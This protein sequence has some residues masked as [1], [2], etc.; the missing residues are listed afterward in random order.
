MTVKRWM[1]LAA[2]FAALFLVQHAGLEREP[3][4]EKER[5]LTHV[6]DLPARDMIPTYVASLFMGAF[7]AVAIDVLWIQLR[8][9]EEE[10][11]WYERREILKMIS[12]FQPRNPEVWAHLGW[13]SAYN[14]ANG[15]SDPDR[16]WEWARFGLEWLRDGV[17]RLPKSA[18]LK[19]ELARTLSHK[20]SWNLGTLDQDFLK[21]V[22]GDKELQAKLRPGG[23]QDPGP[24]LTAFE[25]A[26]LWMERARDLI[27]AENPEG[28][29]TQMGLYLYTD[30]LDGFIR[31]AMYLQGMYRWKQG[32]RKGAKKW[33]V[34]AGHHVQEMI[35]KQKD[36]YKSRISGIHEH[37]V[38]FYF[39]LPRVVDLEEKALAGGLKEKREYLEA[40]QKL[41]IGD[42]RIGLLDQQFLWSERDRNAPLSKLKRELTGDGLEC[43]DSPKLITEI[44]PDREFTANLE[45]KGSDIDVYRIPF[46]PPP[47]DDHGHEGPR[48]KDPPKP[49]RFVMT[50]TRPPETALGLK[51]TVTDQLHREL[52]AAEIR[53]PSREIE[54]EARRYGYYTVRVE[55]LEAEAPPP[56]PS[57]Y[58]LKYEKRP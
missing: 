2:L 20:P 33:F 41:V 42:E 6:G 44:E 28:E 26:I 47:R 43:N 48:P 54:F 13:H 51:V 45:P 17:D 4:Y 18:Y 50:V 27:H 39:G 57:T 1:A 21:R 34:R 25:L 8:K 32:D 37:F 58:R 5:A 55:P 11:R 52:A 38:T 29:K 23:G 24:P 3:E 16:A 19:F 9:V 30:T 22:E 46:P 56:G 31:E 49:V 14:V 15:F 7:R 12:Y 10:R 53:E 40:L 36:Y 35:G